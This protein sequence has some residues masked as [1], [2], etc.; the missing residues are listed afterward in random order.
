MQINFFLT[1]LISLLNLLQLASTILDLAV[2][3]YSLKPIIQRL[4]VTFKHGI[5]QLM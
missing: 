3:G 5:Q 2:S 4:P 1:V